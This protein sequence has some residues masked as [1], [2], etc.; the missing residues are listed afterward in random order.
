METLLVK[1]LL[2]EE[3]TSL[4]VEEFPRRGTRRRDRGIDKR[5]VGDLSPILK[6]KKKHREV[7][8]GPNVIE[9]SFINNLL[10]HSHTE[11][12]DQD[13][14]LLD[15]VYPLLTVSDSVLFHHI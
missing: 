14:V 9:E 5:V 6:K 12:W 7:C 11:R 15:P 3:D 8:H 4:G 10:I 13:S 1:F 2:N